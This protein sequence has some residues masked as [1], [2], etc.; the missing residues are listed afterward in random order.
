MG[1]CHTL[2]VYAYIISHCFSYDKSNN[3][4]A[5]TILLIHCEASTDKKGTWYPVEGIMACYFFP[6]Y[7]HKFVPF[8]SCLGFPKLV[9]P[10]LSWGLEPSS[11]LVAD[12][13]QSFSVDKEKWT[14]WLKMRKWDCASHDNFHIKV[15]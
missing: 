8:F 5:S 2:L 7:R 3:L 6:Q 4:E 11:T 10:Q 1:L 14:K 12:E 9:V 13:S 15:L